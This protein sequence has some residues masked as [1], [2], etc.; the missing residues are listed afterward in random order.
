MTE[1]PEIVLCFL[2]LFSPFM[3]FGAA[4]G[5]LIGYL[6]VQRIL[7]H[8]CV[9][10]TQQKNDFV[11]CLAISLQLCLFLLSLGSVLILPMLGSLNDD[12]KI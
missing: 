10:L 7:A 4:F 1:T 2:F 12:W 5:F 3:T 11:K 8:V 6:A 9:F